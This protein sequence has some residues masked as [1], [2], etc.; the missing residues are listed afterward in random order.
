MWPWWDP[1]AAWAAAAADA[2]AH[3]FGGWNFWA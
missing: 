1:V 2:F 3:L